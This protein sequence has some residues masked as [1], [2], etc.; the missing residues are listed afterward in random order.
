M[1]SEFKK[2]ISLLLLM[3]LHFTGVSQTIKVGLEALERPQSVA[4]YVS[5]GAYKVLADG[6]EI[7]VLNSGASV[8][9]LSSGN[10]VIAVISGKRSGPFQ[11]LKLRTDKWDSEIRLRCISPKRNDKYLQDNVIFKKQQGGLLCINE[12]EI[13]KYVAGV[14]EGEAG[15][16][17]TAEYYKVQA[18]ISRTYAL[19][20]RTRHI[21]DGYNLCDKVHCQVYHGKARFEPA[22]PLSTWETKGTVIVDQDIQLITAAFHSNCGGKTLNSEAVWSK[23]LS[24]CKSVADTFC[25]TQPHS[26]WEKTIPKAQWQGYLQKQKEFSSDSL[27]QAASEGYF[28]QSKGLYFGDSIP[29]KQMR[30]DLGL[31][32]TFFSVHEDGDA[33]VLTGRGFGHGVGL[34]QEGAMRMAELGF[35]YNEILHFYYSDVHLLHLSVLNFFRD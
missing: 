7:G 10:G 33:M 25:L 29:L 21:Y 13:E 1:T 5:S 22:I 16:G 12:L 31:R 4:C 6:L 8:E 30:S 9:V 27:A 3:A 24:Y 15:K 19:A 11:E 35:K 2:Y 20:N 17:H 23:P 28:P 18:I 14:V 32:S 26:H 34:C